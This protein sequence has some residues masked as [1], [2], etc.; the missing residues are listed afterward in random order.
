MSFEEGLKK[1]IDWYLQYQD[2]VE[3]VVTGEYKDYYRRVYGD[4]E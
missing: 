4:G 1:T 2:W 3:S